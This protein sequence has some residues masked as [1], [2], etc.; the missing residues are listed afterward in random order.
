MGRVRCQGCLED[1]T[2]ESARSPAGD[3]QPASIRQLFL[4]VPS[5]T[6]VAI[7]HAERDRLSILV[8]V[9]LIAPETWC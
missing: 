8:Q 6:P 1:S 5:V 7:D 9:E 3:E 4:D 2:N